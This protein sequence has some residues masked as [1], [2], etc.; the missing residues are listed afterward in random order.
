MRS[1]QYRC[2]QY[3]CTSIDANQYRCTCVDL[4]VDLL[5]SRSINMLSVT[6]FDPKG[7]IS[8]VRIQAGLYLDML[9]AD[10]S[11]NAVNVHPGT[12][13]VDFEVYCPPPP[14]PPHLHACPPGDLLI[15]MVKEMVIILYKKEFRKMKK[16]SYLSLIWKRWKREMTARL[17]VTVSSVQTWLYM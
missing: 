16:K 4:H 12:S 6:D 8:G 13:Q 2:V 15:T 11:P 9:D 5:V 3:R 17:P 10:R 7:I 14:P 1:N